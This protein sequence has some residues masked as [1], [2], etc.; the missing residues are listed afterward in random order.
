M[1]CFSMAAFRHLY[2]LRGMLRQTATWTSRPR[3]G[4]S[5]KALYGLFISM[6]G[7]QLVIAC[8]DRAEVQYE[9]VQKKIVRGRFGGLLVCW[10][11]N[12]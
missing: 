10:R 5:L 12:V 6:K 3:F 8:F 4:V 9:R 7:T 2:W 1:G 11:R